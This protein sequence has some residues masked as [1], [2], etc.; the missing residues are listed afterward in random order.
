[1]TEPVFIIAEAGVNHDGSVEDAVRL[2]DAAA[3]AGADCVKFQ[4]FQAEALASIHADKA[5]YQKRTTSA[6]QSQ[7][8]MLKQLELPASAYRA[9]VERARQR[10]I[11]F[12]STP[13]DSGSLSFLLH[14]L[15]L[16]RIKVGSGDMNNAPMLLTIAAAR[17]DVILSTG[18][19]TFAEVEEALSVLA[20]GY[21]GRKEPPSRAGFAAA[22]A[23]GTVRAAL[24]GKVT[25][26]HCTTEYPA[27]A[28]AVNL[29]AMDTLRDHFGLPVGYSDHTLGP[30]IS[31]AA[32]ARGAVMI[33]KHLTLD[34]R[35]TG[36]DHA[37][38]LEPNAF[39]A[40]VRSIRRVENAFGDGRKVPQRAETA[41]IPIARKALVA[42]RPIAVGEPFTADNLTLKRPGIGLPPIAL[43]DMIGKT[44]QRAYDADEAI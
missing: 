18:M 11:V 41:N 23:D 1:M 8:A 3:D 10:G 42:A 24:V 16:G 13:F 33:E 14:E 34:C 43:W 7:Q 44:A 6:D 25:L 15:E 31:I 20:F 17:R 22:W 28:E 27:P 30:D 9:L 19:A 38:S 35:R 21:A 2:I 37:A 29:K 40:L 5:A 26:L 39:A 36:P 12:L 32:V 4:T